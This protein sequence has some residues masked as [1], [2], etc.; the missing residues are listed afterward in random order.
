MNTLLRVCVWLWVMNIHV[1]HTV[2]I[3]PTCSKVNWKCEHPPRHAAFDFFPCFAILYHACGYTYVHTSYWQICW[4]CELSLFPFSFVFFLSY[5]RLLDRQFWRF[6]FQYV[7]TSWVYYFIPSRETDRNILRCTVEPN[8]CPFSNK[9]TRSIR[10]LPDQLIHTVN[11]TWIG[12]YRACNSSLIV[13]N[14]NWRGNWSGC[15]LIANYIVR[16]SSNSN[17]RNQNE[18]L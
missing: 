11:D 17:S 8:S 1:V 15:K 3:N 18:R 12:M 9:L 5:L 6:L 4:L 2:T 14:I 10:V 13:C 16:L 7:R